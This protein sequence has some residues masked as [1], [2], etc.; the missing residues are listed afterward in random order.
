VTVVTRRP[1][2]AERPPG[3]DRVGVSGARI[4]AVTHPFDATRAG[5]RPEHGG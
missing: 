3:P 5:C 1:V 2:G 4:V